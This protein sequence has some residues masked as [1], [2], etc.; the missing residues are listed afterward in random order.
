MLK[1]KVKQI[2]DATEKNNYSIKEVIE[3]NYQ[4]LIQLHYK[5]IENDILDKAQKNDFKNINNKKIITGFVTIDQRI[6][7]LDALYPNDSYENC[8]I[9]NGTSS[10]LKTKTSQLVW[11]PLFDYKSEKKMFV[12]NKI[13]FYLTSFGEKVFRDI[14]SLAQ[15]NDIKI[16][17]YYKCYH[18][19]IKTTLFTTPIYEKHSPYINDFDLLVKYTIALS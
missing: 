16:E 7:E 5:K 17:L 19:N 12:G 13:T 2:I 18:W 1:D 15:M 3:Q 10:I 8:T 11:H 4:N 9:S 6:I 14:S